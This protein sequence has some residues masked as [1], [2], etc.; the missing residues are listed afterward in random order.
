MIKLLVSSLFTIGS[1]S[2]L[3]LAGPGG[4][5]GGSPDCIEECPQ[6]AWADAKA[7]MDAADRA[8]GAARPW[9]INLGNRMIEGHTP[10]GRIIL[11]N[12]VGRTMDSMV[13]EATLDDGSVVIAKYTNDCRRRLNNVTTDPIDEYF[14]LMATKDSG[15]TPNV[16]GLSEPA[17][18][19][20]ADTPKS[21]SK[22]MEAHAVKCLAAGA[23]VRLLLQER[24][25][26][27]MEIYFQLLRRRR[28]SI[29][30]DG[31]RFLRSVLA[32]G[33]K[34]V[35]VLQK[36]HKKGIIHGDIHAGNIMF[37]SPKGSIEDYDLLADDDEEIVL[38]DFGYARYFV[39]E[40]GTEPVQP[41]LPGMNPM[42][43][44]LWNLFH[45]RTGRRDDIYRVFDMLSMILSDWS[46]ETALKNLIAAHIR[47]NPKEAI[48]APRRVIRQCKT[49]YPLFQPSPLLVT[50]CCDRMGLGEKMRKSVQA[51]LESVFVNKVKRLSHP[52]ATP[53]YDSIIRRLKRIE[54]AV[55]KYSVDE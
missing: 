16:Y 15:I 45:R 7:G 49:D 25:G 54:R 12:R 44:S 8:F 6:D 18:V 41:M 2:D 4:P 26:M 34:S 19:T 37:K 20:I 51:D 53:E 21:Y 33:W 50:G 30:D 35:E 39:N 14:L 27:D 1:G 55:R 32:L 9:S 10:V 3:S 40:I 24:A 31:K 36:L 48:D 38:V 11:T 5:A 43:L 23:E 52:D 17:M 22:F 29:G 47:D 42:L 13:W 28:S 46:R